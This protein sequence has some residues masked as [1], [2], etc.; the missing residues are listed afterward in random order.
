MKLLDTIEQA[1]HG[2]TNPAPHEL[3]AKIVEMDITFEKV[4][5]YIAKPSQLPYGRRVLFQ[6]DEFEAILIHLP[7]GSQTSIHDHGASIGCAF[8]LEG[9]MTNTLYE[10]GSEGY[11]YECGKSTLLP[12]QFL[13]APHGQI[14]QMSN[15][16]SE[17]MLSFH[18]YAPCMTGMKA[19]CTYEQVL[20]YVI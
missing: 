8:I 16:S 5:P 11:V 6:S 13:Y 18:I 7:A 1:F 15:T 3:R 19:Y 10:L 20:D 14:H 2:V 12:N 4:A 17:R 9:Q